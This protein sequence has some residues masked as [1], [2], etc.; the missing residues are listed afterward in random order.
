MSSTNQNPNHSRYGSKKASL[1]H[2]SGYL[3]I[4]VAIGG[5]HERKRAGKMPSTEY[6][7]SGMDERTLRTLFKRGGL[8]SRSQFGDW[9]FTPAGGGHRPI[10]I[11]ADDVPY[12]L[13]L[14]GEGRYLEVVAYHMSKLTT[15]E[16]DNV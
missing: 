14:K 7:T 15:G 12:D 4:Y 11:L 9:I 1:L 6:M 3:D 10:N 16:K 13:L 8:F 2:H 5:T